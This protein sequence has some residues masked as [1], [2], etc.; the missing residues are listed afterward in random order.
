MR[1][2]WIRAFTSTS[3]KNITN[4]TTIMWF[5]ETSI[6]QLN[7]LTHANETQSDNLASLRATNGTKGIS[8]PLKTRQ[9]K[10]SLPSPSHPAKSPS[11]S[12][13]F[14]IQEQLPPTNVELIH[15][16]TPTSLLSFSSSTPPPFSTLRRSIRQRKHATRAA[17]KKQETSFVRS[18]VRLPPLP[19][20][21]RPV[22]PWN[23]SS[24]STREEE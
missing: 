14:C 15:H 12:P 3:T 19:G 21:K 23:D 9:R 4:E 10:R 20:I 11:R 16:P 8:S 18:F 6:N 7:I 17:A 24:S 5:N 1:T 2:H 22:D 13:F